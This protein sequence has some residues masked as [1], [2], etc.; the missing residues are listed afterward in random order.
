VLSLLGS[1]SVPYRQKPAGQLK[2]GEATN[3]V[4]IANENRNNHKPGPKQLKQTYRSGR[5]YIWSIKK[6]VH[7]NFAFVVIRLVPVKRSLKLT[8]LLMTGGPFN[9]SRNVPSGVLDT[10]FSFTRA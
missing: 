1:K 10:G 8:D 9:P 4:V 5:K 2:S 3:K 7:A 6:S